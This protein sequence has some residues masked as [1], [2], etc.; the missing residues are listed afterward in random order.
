VLYEALGGRTP[1]AHRETLGSLILAIYV[2]DPP[3][4]RQHAPWV[5]G[6]VAAI[7]HRAL[8][9]DP[10]ARFQS[11]AEMLAALQGHLAHGYALD[12]SML[13]PAARERTQSITPAVVRGAAVRLSVRGL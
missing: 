5:A 7:V 13:V 6:E 8:A 10:G 9:R 3:P 1:F 12:E 4:L 11:A 2:E